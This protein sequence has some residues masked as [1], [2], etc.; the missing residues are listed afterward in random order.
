MERGTTT[1][2]EMMSSHLGKLGIDHVATHDP[3]GCEAAKRIRELL[4]GSE[5]GQFRPMAELLMFV[6]ARVQLQG[7]VIFP[8]LYK[9]KIPVVCDRFYPS[10]HAYQ[11]AG[12]SLS[13]E[14]IDSLVKLTSAGHGPDVIVYIDIPVDESIRRLK[15]K[16]KDRFEKEDEHFVQR[17]VT[18]YRQ[19]ADLPQ[20]P[21][22]PFHFQVDGRH[23]P[24]VIH[25][26]VCGVLTTHFPDF[27]YLEPNSES[28]YR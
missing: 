15:D 8:A 26:F 28:V 19:M 4:L 7:D 25:E 23:P 16:K 9:Q 17:V 20:K 12:S 10:T 5:V 3:G 6:A 1:Q 21:G 27:P 14:L 24:D 13:L 22:C 18:K 2:T 11:G